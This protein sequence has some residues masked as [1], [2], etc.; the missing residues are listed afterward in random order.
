MLVCATRS[1]VSQK[2]SDVFVFFSELFS[3]LQLGRAFVL[4]EAALF[5]MAYMRKDGLI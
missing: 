1:G 5:A 3:N 4:T 2:G